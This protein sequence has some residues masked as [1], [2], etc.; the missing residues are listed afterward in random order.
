MIHLHVTPRRVAPYVIG[1]ATG[2][3]VLARMRRLSRQ[4]A[5]DAPLYFFLLKNSDVVLAMGGASVVIWQLARRRPRQ[6]SQTATL[7]PSNGSA[8]TMPDKSLITGVVHELRQ[9]FTA[10]LLG[11]G[12]IRR[13]ANTGDTEAIPNLVKRLNTVVRRGI[14]AIN[15]LEPSDSTNRR[16]REYGA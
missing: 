4:P 11:L 3:H 15:V 7:T 16:E 13:K 9:I 2:L 10:L 12:I 1:G 8:E 6:L 14:D 5:T